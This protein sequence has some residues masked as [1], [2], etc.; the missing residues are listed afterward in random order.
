LRHI[1]GFVD[2]IREDSD[3]KL[4]EGSTRSF[5]IITE[6]TDQ[7]RRLIEDLLSFSRTGRAT[8][9]LSP[10]SNS[11]LVREA[12]E[13]VS[14]DISGRDIRWDVGFLPDVTADRAMLRQVWINLLS[15]AVKYTG[16]R[17]QAVIAVG[18]QETTDE[19]EFFVRDNGAGFDMRYVQKLFGVFQRLHRADQFQGTGIGLA[20]VRRIVRRHEGRTWAEGTP[21]AGATF[22][23]SLPRQP[24]T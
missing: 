5:R 2:L 18:C 9:E 17:E 15:N 3:S 4:S 20:N 13:E 6:A 8:M 24:L 11:S 1:N 14:R 7:M 19:F 10:V 23:F 16:Q 22:Y 12:R 21:N